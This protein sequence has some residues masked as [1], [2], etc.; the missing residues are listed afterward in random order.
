MEKLKKQISK[1]LLEVETQLAALVAE[2]NSQKV[3]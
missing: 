2:T 3:I 1:D